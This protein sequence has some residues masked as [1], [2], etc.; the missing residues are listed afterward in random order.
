[1][2]E[3][4]NPYESPKETTEST[5]RWFRSAFVPTFSFILAC[6]AP[7]VTLLLLTDSDVGTRQFVYT[8]LGSVV[9]VFV[10]N[11]AL[12][13]AFQVRVHTRGIRGYNFW[14]RYRDVDWSS[15]VSARPINTLGL[16]Y[17][18]VACEEGF[19]LWIPLFL[20]DQRRFVELVCELAGGD[21]PLTRFFTEASAPGAGNR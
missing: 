13:A 14:G 5:D 3:T 21:H 12:V 11:V 8:M 20:V 19:V 2:G 9:C 15:M 6:V 18:R 16:R 17:V 4:V 7:L 1:M 10:G